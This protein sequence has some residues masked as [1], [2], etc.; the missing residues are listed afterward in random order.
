M[1]MRLTQNYTNVRRS[2]KGSKHI[3]PGQDGIHYTYLKHLPIVIT[4]YL[5]KSYETCLKSKY[6]PDHWESGLV[7]ILLKPNKDLRDPKYF[8]PITLLAALDKCMEGIVST[9]VD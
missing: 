8:R 9:A 4:R 3:A 7:A 6:F 5:A 2:L 1:K